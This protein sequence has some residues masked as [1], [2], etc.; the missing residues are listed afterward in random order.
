MRLGAGA[1]AAWVGAVVQAE[2]IEVQE[3][4]AQESVEAEV[5]RFN[6]SLKASGW[7]IKLSSCYESRH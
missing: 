1:A 2:G 5:R 6:S 3:G 4:L 7:T